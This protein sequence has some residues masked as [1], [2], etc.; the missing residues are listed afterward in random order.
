M[1][2]GVKVELQAFDSKKWFECGLLDFTVPVSV[3]TGVVKNG[4]QIANCKG[5]VFTITD[6]QKDVIKHHCNIRGSIHKY[7]NNGDHNAND[8]TNTDLHN[9]LKNMELDYNI[10]LSS[11]YLHGLEFGVNVETP[12]PVSQVLH[13][14]VASKGR[15]FTAIKYKGKT[16]GKQIQRDEYSIKLYNKG[17]QYNMGS[18]NLM[19]IEVSVNKMRLLAKYGIFTLSDLLDTEK[20]SPLG[21]LLLDH[22][23][24]II[25]YDKGVKWKELTPFERKKLLYYV[26][27]RN[28]ED[29]NRK[30][31]Y[32]A[33]KHFCELMAKHNALFTHKEIG[34]LI[35]QKWEELTTVKC[36][37][38]HQKNM[39]LC[40][41]KMS[42]FPQLEYRVKPWSSIIKKNI[43]KNT[44]KT[45]DKITKKCRVC[46]ADISH[47]R[48]HSL[49]CS[50]KC[51]NS[52]HASI[53]KQQRHMK[54]E[55]EL[56]Q[57]NEL[58]KNLQQ[59]N[60]KM[61]VTYSN[62]GQHYTDQLE[63][64][65]IQVTAEWINRI[66][67]VTVQETATE[68]ILLTSY[69]ARKLIKEVS[70]INN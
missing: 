37:H 51:N 69:R 16:V 13:N 15:Q 63:Q 48:T 56:K 64:K 26:A 7:H 6:T 33:R 53:R 11:A 32:R 4:T 1:I 18:Y 29:F 10:C 38:F 3:S 47:K 35:A 43:I 42:T 70:K 46:S 49:Y 25:Y 8:F 20:I 19:R 61:L 34:N 50:K 65:E 68:Y 30:Q 5:L 31:R 54:K 45:R 36:L 27:P 58:L 21:K 41:R 14:L 57:L 40:S 62:N 66:K 55:K 39:K 44:L 52:Y 23:N 59:S 67:W 28:W 22:W 60:L 9:T 17:E 24:S 12:I 2:D